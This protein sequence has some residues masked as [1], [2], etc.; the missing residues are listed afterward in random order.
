LIYGFDPAHA[1]RISAYE[2][3]LRQRSRLLRDGVTDESWLKALETQMVE[4]G[5]AITAARLEMA[6][7]LD[8]A[9]HSRNGP[10]PEVGVSVTGIVESWLSETSALEVEDRLRETLRMSRQ[11]DS[12]T[13]G[14][15][16]G[17]HRSDLVVRHLGKNIMA[18]QC[19][20]GEQKALLISIVL[21][22]LKLQ[23]AETGRMPILLLDEVAAHLDQEKREALFITLED[24]GAQ[25]WM[26]GTEPYVFEN[27]MKHSVGFDV[28]EGH[29]T[30]LN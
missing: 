28:Q 5:V 27:V 4:R 29:L 11:R 24:L 30:R 13:G 26:T 3:A 19:S 18:D 16:I 17:P 1:G 7:R 21:G 9:C 20:T 25:V 10:F 8:R 2:K 22:D 23:S 15:Q 14:A 6:D 12:E